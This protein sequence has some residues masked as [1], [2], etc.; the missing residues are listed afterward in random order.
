[1]KPSERGLGSIVLPNWRLPGVVGMPLYSPETGPD[2]HRFLDIWL[3][4]ISSSLYKGA[5]LKQITLRSGISVV[6]DIHKDAKWMDPW[7]SG[8]NPLTLVRAI[9]DEE[10]ASGKPNMVAERKMWGWV[11]ELSSVYRDAAVMAIYPLRGIVR[12][13]ETR[14]VFLLPQKPIQ[15]LSKVLVANLQAR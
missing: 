9:L 7:S 8:E 5:F 13:G 2:P 12:N 4:M 15:T 14:N 6:L 1:M 11:A 10:L 3:N